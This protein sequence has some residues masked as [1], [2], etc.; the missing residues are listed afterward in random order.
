MCLRLVNSSPGN[1]VP[2]EHRV[3]KEAFEAHNGLLAVLEQSPRVHWV[4][5]ELMLAISVALSDHIFFVP[6]NLVTM[7]V[8]G[9]MRNLRSYQQVGSAS[10][11]EIAT[12]S[13]QRGSASSPMMI[14]LFSQTKG[15]IHLLSLAHHPFLS[16]TLI[17]HRQLALSHS[18]MSATWFL[19]CDSYISLQGLA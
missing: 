9:L 4:I 17:H 19:A 10:D 11:K 5:Q 3:L 2:A 18:H 14:Q 7:T 8:W 6:R 15:F 16:L 1:F 13:S 12:P